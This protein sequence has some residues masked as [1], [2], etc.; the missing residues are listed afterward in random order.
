MLARK[1]TGVLS[2]FALRIQLRVTCATGATKL[3]GLLAQSPSAI[4][5]LRFTRLPAALKQA[6]T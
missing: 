5:G 1:S 6:T 4:L 2:C 3:S